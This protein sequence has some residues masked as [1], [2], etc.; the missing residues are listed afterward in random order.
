MDAKLLRVAYAIELLLAIVA[1]FTLWSQVGGQGHLDLMPW[2]WKLPVGLG[3]AVA[4]VRATAAEGERRRKWMSLLLVLLLAAGV[5]T[6]YAHINEPE[7]DQD[8]NA[9]ASIGVTPSSCGW[10]PS[11]G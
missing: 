2:Y 5:L 11:S 6:F 3:A 1:A 9:T 4:F 7:E 8:E 10:R